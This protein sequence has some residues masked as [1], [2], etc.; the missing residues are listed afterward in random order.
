MSNF[1][2]LCR[3]LIGC[4]LQV[5]GKT[6][7]DESGNFKTPGALV[8]KSLTSRGNTTVCGKLVTDNI[9]PKTSGGNVSMNGNVTI[10]GNITLG[11]VVPKDGSNVSVN[12]NVSVDGNI[13]VNGNVSVDDSYYVGGSQVVTSPQN[14]PGNSDA[15]LQNTSDTCNLILQVLRTHGLINSI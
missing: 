4:N 14:D 6:V 11:N 15:T 12:G 10:C 13:S 3:D 1:G 5:K 7:I 9:E 8:S 2:P